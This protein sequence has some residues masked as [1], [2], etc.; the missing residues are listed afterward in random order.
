MEYR[1]FGLEVGLVE[2]LSIGVVRISDYE[3][4]NQKTIRMGEEQ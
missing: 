4:W 3:G 1:G 2:S